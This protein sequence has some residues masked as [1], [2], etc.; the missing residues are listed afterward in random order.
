MGTPKLRPILSVQVNALTDCKGWY[1]QLR[2]CL[3]WR[4][5]WTQHK[6]TCL[7][8]GRNK[9]SVFTLPYRYVVAKKKERAII[10]NHTF[11]SF[12]FYLP[13]IKKEEI[14]SFL[15]INWNKIVIP[16]YIYVTFFNVEHAV[17][18]QHNATVVGLTATFLFYLW[19]FYTHE[20]E[21]ILD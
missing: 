21:K 2:I 20:I 3:L 9:I 7:L 18:I 6:S 8:S 13:L 10:S 5:T 11:N 1:L 4:E 19:S 14:Y 12:L 15:I 16:V 17:L